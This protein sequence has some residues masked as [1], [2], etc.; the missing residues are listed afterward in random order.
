[1]NVK[2]RTKPQKADARNSGFTLIE[3]LVVIAII[4][5]LAALLLPALSQAKRRA[6]GIQCMSNTRQIML[7]WKMY[8]D[9]NGDILPPNDYP[10]NSG[11]IED[12]TEKNWVFGSMAVNNDVLHGGAGYYNNNPANNQLIGVNPILS[13]LAAYNQN[14]V[15]YKC[16]ADIVLKQ[17]RVRP[18]S[19]SM[20]SCVG[21]RW[22]SAGFGGGTAV[23][24]SVPGEAVGGGWSTGSYHDPNGVY[25]CY[26]KTTSF[27]AP[28]PSDTWVIM[29][30]N[31]ATI[32][33]ACLSICMQP[34]LVDYPANYHNGGAAI[35][36]AD[37]H[38]EMHRWV[39]VFAQNPAGQV[40]TPVL[41]P[42]QDLA[43]IQPRT[44]A[45]K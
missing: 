42:S 20:N 18:R 21:T 8:A 14:I 45:L 26:G 28:G 19:V 30:E 39:D 17:G 24:G 10:F 37:G 34:Y 33:D 12:G 4:A 11:A 25:R 5:I 15:I 43:W 1:M 7:T 16:P 23:P 40:E 2:V 29:D 32:N 13:C 36:F 41:G 22:Y 6:Q 9:D 44:T 35:S 27:T 3:L 31:P 38:V